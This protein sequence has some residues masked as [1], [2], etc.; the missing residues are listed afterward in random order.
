ML[1]SI[2]QVRGIID[3]YN[4]AFDIDLSVSCLSKRK[5]MKSMIKNTIQYNTLM[6]TQNKYKQHQFVLLTAFKLDKKKRTSKANNKKKPN[7]MYKTQ[8]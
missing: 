8:W 1:T 7:K 2:S 6:C 3:V 4:Q 5:K